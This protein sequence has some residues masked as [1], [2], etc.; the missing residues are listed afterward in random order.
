MKTI[1]PLLKLNIFILIII[2]ISM[3]IIFFYNFYTGFKSLQPNMFYAVKV[4]GDP[5]VIRLYPSERP[6]V[7]DDAVRLFVKEAILSIYNYNSTNYKD[8]NRYQDYFTNV[9]LVRFENGFIRNTELSINEGIQIFR[10]VIIEEPIMVQ[11]MKGINVWQFYA[12]ILT[13]YKSELRNVSVPRNVI[14][15]VREEKIEDS[16]KGIAIDDIRI[17]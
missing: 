14:V 16:K 15:F 2:L 5:E 1:T 9:G 4:V 6:L 17:R 3:P 7:N 12:K 11:K 13:Q 10:T 8:R